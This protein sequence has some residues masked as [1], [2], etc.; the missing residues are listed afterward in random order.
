[1]GFIHISNQVAVEKQKKLLPA[2]GR[3][4]PKK[5]GTKNPEK[6]SLSHCE[7]AFSSYLEPLGHNQQMNDSASP[8]FIAAVP[9]PNAFN[10]SPSLERETKNRIFTCVNILC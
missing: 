1:M 5:F 3:H 8:H 4:L 7:Y 2:A 9:P 10:E 6:Y